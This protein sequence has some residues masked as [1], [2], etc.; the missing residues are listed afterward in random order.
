MTH[1]SASWL[2]VNDISFGTAVTNGIDRVKF[3]TDALFSGHG[4]L[5]DVAVNKWNPAEPQAGSRG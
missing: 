4:C 5:D 3:A 2:V 1:R